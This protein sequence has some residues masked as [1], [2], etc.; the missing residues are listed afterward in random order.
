[1]FDAHAHPG[2]D[3]THE[4]FVCSASCDEYDVLS[5]WKYKAIGSIPEGSGGVD[6]ALMEKAASEGFHIG[7]IGLDRRFPDIAAQTIV[8][9]KALAIA[10]KYNRLA[11][12]HVVR[13]YGKVLE[14]ISEL[15][16]KSFIIHGFTGSSEIARII[17]E[18]GGIISLSP[19]SEGT[20]HFRAILSLPFVTETDMVTGPEERMVLSSW[21]EKL[22]NLTGIDVEE[23]TERM[24]MEALR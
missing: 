3:I 2:K 22:K 17:I 1:M 13:E 16:I 6:F 10:K 4:A 5:H 23:R 20:K 12:I 15:G 24:M 21:N 9:R 14:I 18:K 7:E 19:R 11:V 8:F